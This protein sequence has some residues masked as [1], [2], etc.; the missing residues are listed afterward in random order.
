MFRV[1]GSLWV[2]Q[3]VLTHSNIFV[4]DFPKQLFLSYSLFGLAWF[5]NGA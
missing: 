4:V 2:I 5:G 3:I 1:R